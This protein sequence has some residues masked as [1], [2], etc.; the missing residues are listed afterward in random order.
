MRSLLVQ[1]V[2]DRR[3][4]HSGLAHRVTDLVQPLHHIPRRE[5]AGD[6]GALVRIDL[7]AAFACCLRPRRDD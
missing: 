4:R 2:T 3:R 1:Q 6:A 5:Q 7:E